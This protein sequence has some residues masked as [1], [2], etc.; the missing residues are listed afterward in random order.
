[1]NK[2]T[3]L[4]LIKSICEKT[5]PDGYVQLPVTDSDIADEFGRLSTHLEKTNF[6]WEN[7]F[8]KDLIFG[9]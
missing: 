8:L 4:K 6:N 5:A 3:R 9:S 2:E 7:E 1:M